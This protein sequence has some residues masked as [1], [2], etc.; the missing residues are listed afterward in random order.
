MFGLVGAVGCS[1]ERPATR[2]AACD[3]PGVSADQVKAGLVLSDTGVGSVAMSSARSGL[4][5]R[6]GLANAEGGVRGR[7]IVYRWRDDAG[8]PSQNAQVTK[9]LVDHESVLGIV[10][11]T[12]ALGGSLDETQARGIPVVGLAVPSWA[13]YQ[14]LFAYA[15]ETSPQT[16]GRYI[17]QGG[18]KKVGILVTGTA[19]SVIQSANEYREDFEA[20]GLA[21][22]APISYASSTDSP[23]QV[24]R[25]L[26]AA[27][28]DSL[29]GLTSAEDFAAVVKA[30]REA[31]PDL[32]VSVTLSGY[33][34]SLLPSLGPALAGVSIPVYFRPFEAGGDALGRYREAMNRYAPET[35]Q[36]EQ[37][38]AMYGY[39]FAD[40]F[41]RG[42]DLAGDC[43][44]REGFI[45]ALRGVSDYD[46]G[47][48]LAP[49]D[50]GANARQPLSCYAFVQV[51]PSGTAFGVA[52]ERLCADGTGR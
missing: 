3:S 17:L 39:L 24:A 36:P 41:I 19:E 51:N 26:A 33:A 38:F 11:V 31:G 16:V 52:R 47:G 49:V 22:A 5:A 46:A 29:V 12:T 37:E 20:V 10:A 42:L 28:V 7:Q 6:I 27:G 21:T 2:A 44:T 18:G 13:E 48:L 43:P 14:N 8:S 9:D 32:A 45:S 34:R 1:A 23:L 4:D 35:T 25:Q 50:L 40:M 30:A 15:Y